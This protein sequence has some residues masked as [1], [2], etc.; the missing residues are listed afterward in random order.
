MRAELAALDTTKPRSFLF[1]SIL[2][3][4]SNLHGDGDLNSAAR[5][6]HGGSLLLL[7]GLASA[8]PPLLLL[9][10]LDGNIGL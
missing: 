8:S 7:G 2:G 10:Q 9:D 6:G 5:A 3:R 4:V 1:L